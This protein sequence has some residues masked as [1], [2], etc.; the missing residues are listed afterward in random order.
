MKLV[1][2]TGSTAARRRSAVRIAAAG[3]AA[4]AVLVLGAAVGPDGVGFPDWHTRLGRALLRL[5][6]YRVGAG[7]AVGGGLS[8]AGV[9]LQAVLRNPLADPY[10]LG[11]S[12]GGALGAAAV[13][14]LGAASSSALA[15][16]AGAFVAA[17]L[18]LV[19]VYVVASRGAGGAPSVYGLI[20]SGSIVSAMASSLLM[21]LVSLADVEGLH[22]VV[23]WMLGS[24]QVASGPLLAV[25]AACTL[26]AVALCLGLARE[27]NALTLGREMAHHL[28]VRTDLAVALAL[29]AA[30]LAAASAV[31]LAGLIGFVGLVVPH[32]VRPLTGA[33]HR[34]LVPV[35]AVAG[36]VFLV[37]CDALARLALAPVEIPAGVI[38]A[39]SGGP[40]FL[41]LLRRRKQGWVE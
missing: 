26:A 14:L 9:V 30:T 34:R 11:V 38:T 32:A 22:S 6:L 2:E 41:V 24:L 10:V 4:V 23:W 1:A 20:L 25:C 29:G 15:L 40:F 18:T 3:A 17:A 7:L 5:R 39:L 36:G 27:L 16:P 21:V 8:V 37:G 28:G 33:D 19:L 12:G 35:A 13:I 31:A